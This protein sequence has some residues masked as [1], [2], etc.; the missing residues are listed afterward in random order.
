MVWRGRNG[1]AF[2]TESLPVIKEKSLMKRIIIITLVLLVICIGFYIGY[3]KANQAKPSPKFV[4]IYSLLP[5]ENIKYIS[6][7][8]PEAREMY[9]RLSD[10]QINEPIVTCWRWTKN[11]TFRP[12]SMSYE[13]TSLSAILAMITNLE[14]YEIEIAEPY[15][16]KDILGDII[17]REDA[18]PESLLV[19]L[20]DIC[21]KELQ[22]PVKISFQMVSKNVWV[23]R[24]SYQFKPVS[25][26]EDRI[27]I[28]EKQV[29]YTRGDRGG[30]DFNAFLKWLEKYYIHQWIINEVENPPQEKL[31]WHNNEPRNKTKNAESVFRHLTEQTGL[32]FTKEIR[33]VKILVVE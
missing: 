29:G 9:N 19:S 10:M 14:P 20:E 1:L 11:G 21:H 23:V 7:P 5:S 13:K 33:P 27:E 3:Q 12:R 18:S 22:L 31:Q 15:R 17:Y 16:A 2:T 25:K 32:I 8:L 6:V 4:E 26:Q 24:G 28:Y 30:G